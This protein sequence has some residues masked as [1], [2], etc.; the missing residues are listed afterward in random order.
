M[1]PPNPAARFEKWRRATVS[2]T[3][4]GPATGPDKVDGLPTE[5]SLKP[6]LKVQWPTRRQRMSGR[7]SYHFGSDGWVGKMAA[8]LTQKKREVPSGS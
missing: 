2:P 3:T 7:T 1:A 4:T 6:Q 8:F 5:L